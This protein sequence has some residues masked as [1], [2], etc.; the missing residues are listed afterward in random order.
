MM[1]EPAQLAVAREIHHALRHGL[2]AVDGAD[3]DRGGFDRLEHAERAADE[4]GVARRIDE[5]DVAAR[6][7]E[8]HE[9]RIEGVPQLL[10]LRI[11]VADGGAALEA[12]AARM[13]PDFGE[14][15]LGQQRLTRAGLSHQRNIADVRGRIRHRSRPPSGA[16]R[17]VELPGAARPAG[18]VAAAHS[19]DSG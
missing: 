2:D 3:D 4:I 8:V 1:I 11:E 13:A 6:R 19:A 10:F 7:V 9:R 12:A 17:S 18:Y 14:Q 15:A 16:G 5:I